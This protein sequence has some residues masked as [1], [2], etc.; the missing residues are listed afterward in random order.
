MYVVSAVDE[1]L[2]YPAKIGR[3]SGLHWRQRWSNLRTSFWFPAHIPYVFEFS[4]RK[5]CIDIELAA[6]KALHSFRL[7]GEWFDVEPRT[8]RNVIFH[9][10]KLHDVP[11]LE[12][13][14]RENNP[15]TGE[16]IRKDGIVHSRH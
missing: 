13:F 4:R 3:S 2:E 1:N 8:A 15:I 10:T 16:E 9:M 5:H 14:V 12:Y 11:L 6:Q 7:E